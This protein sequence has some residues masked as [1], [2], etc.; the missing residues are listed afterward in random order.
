MEYYG[1]YDVMGFALG[2]YNQLTALSTPFRVFQ[3]ITDA[4]EIRPVRLGDERS[5]VRV[6]A[7]IRPRDHD[8]GL[9]SVR[10]VNPDTGEVLYLDYRSGT[11]QDAGAFYGA[12]DGVYLRS[13]RG[14]LR[15]APGVTVNAARGGSGVD[16]LVVDG[17]RRH[18]ARRRRHVDQRL[19]RPDR[20]CR[21]AGCE[22]RGRRGHVHAAGA[23]GP[24]ARC[25]HQT[26][27]LKRDQPGVVPSQGGRDP[28]PAGRLPL[29]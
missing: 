17:T 18:L 11:G 16:T 9:R 19:G 5:T 13:G 23:L 3:G 15:Y 8:T 4:G 1:A 21:C 14:P 6:R 7:T 12:Q 29:P 2:G 10:V 28:D 26:V 22:R 20:P 24:E 27:G 25:P